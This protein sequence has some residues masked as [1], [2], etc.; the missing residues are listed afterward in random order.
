MYNAFVYLFGGF[1]TGVNN[2]ATNV[3]NNAVEAESFSVVAGAS[4][5]SAA[6]AA[7]AAAAS[8]NFKG[9]WS[10]LAG[11]L[12]T[13]ASVAHGG[14]IWALLA[15]LANVATAEPGVDSAWLP[16]GDTML[17]YPK[18]VPSLLLDF[19]KGKTLDP[20][21]TFSRASSA[22]Y[23]GADGLLKTATVGQA[24]FDHDPVTGEC[25]GLLIEEA[26]VNLMTYSEQ[27]D[28]AAWI[29]T[30]SSISANATTA[31]DG[32]T[33][34]DKLVE[35]STASNT[36]VTTINCA[37][38][39]PNQT[40][41]LSVH[42]KAGERS[43]IKLTAWN[44]DAPTN[45]VYASFNVSTGTV[46]TVGNGGNGSGATASIVSV[47]NGWYRCVL[48]GKPDTSGTNSGGGIYLATADNTSTYTGDGTS[49]IYVWGGQVEV[50][51]FATSYIPTI[52]ATVTRSADVVSM[53]GANFSSWFNATEGTIS[54]ISDKAALAGNFPIVWQLSA[55]STTNYMG[56]LH[57]SSSN[58]IRY[59]DVTVGGVNQATLTGGDSALAAGVLTRAAFAYRANDFALSRNGEAAITDTSGTVPTVDR[60]NIG[61]RYDGAVPLNGHI[62]H[63]AY[64]PRRLTNAQL[65]AL[66][67]E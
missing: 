34:G 23:Y 56:L 27:L 50:G 18:C 4:A 33:T 19:A 5:T 25:K 24:R 20:R 45:Q 40:I 1:R 7:S 37:G 54:V 13:P 59:I 63:L 2:I 42:A 11:A 57:N 66:S 53:T 32:T 52:S 17:A 9:N 38:T 44:A 29:K 8:A 49:G 64:W 47:G 35:D 26:R 67:G 31:P 51:S 62:A 65:V 61:A 14:T 3:Y 48:T 55:G 30:R 60:L 36:H 12:N 21:I 16:V 10:A 6:S 46:G 28:N 39:S 15:N 41:T 22:S 58:W 43:W